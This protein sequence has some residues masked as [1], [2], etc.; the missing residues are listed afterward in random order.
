MKAIRDLQLSLNYD[1]STDRILIALG[2][3]WTFWLTIQFVIVNTASFYVY[4]LVFLKND[5]IYFDFSEI[6]V[7]KFCPKILYPFICILKYILLLAMSYY[8]TITVPYFFIYYILYIRMILKIYSGYILETE[9]LAKGM[10]NEEMQIL[11]KRRLVF[12]IKMH[13]EL[14]G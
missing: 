1:Q 11:I 6:Y 14:L 13:K 8:M 4:S 9:N 7:Q 3:K 5:I 12:L 2:R 10:K